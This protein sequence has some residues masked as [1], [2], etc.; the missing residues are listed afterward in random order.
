MILPSVASC[1]SART[2]PP[3]LASSRPPKNLRNEP[4]FFHYVKHINSRRTN[5]IFDPF[6]GG[7]P[8]D[9]YFLSEIHLLDVSHSRRTNLDFIAF[10]DA[11]PLYYFKLF[12]FAK[13]PCETSRIFG[14][15]MST[16]IAF[17]HDL[18]PICLTKFSFS[19]I[20]CGTSRILGGPISI[21][22]VLRLRSEYL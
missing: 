19:N 8:L 4:C 10:A 1:D 6:Q 2:H 11:L 15:P 21:S 17:A 9:L 18:S 16:S 14:G 22:I 20:P 13:I 3:F 12:S 7:T 5:P